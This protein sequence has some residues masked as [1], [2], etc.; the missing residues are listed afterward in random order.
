MCV[1]VRI[2]GYWPELATIGL[3]RRPAWMFVRIPFEQAAPVKI[4]DEFDRPFPRR[5]AFEQLRRIG[6]AEKNGSYL[7]ARQ[8]ACVQRIRDGFQ[9]TSLA[10]H[11]DRKTELRADQ[12]GQF[13][14]IGWV[15]FRF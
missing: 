1:R 2:V 10:G 7:C 5:G 11:V 9:P 12:T 4:A 3:P 15:L 6:N 14:A 13:P 8:F